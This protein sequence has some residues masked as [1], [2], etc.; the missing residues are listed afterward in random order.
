MYHFLL[1]VLHKT[2]LRA[3]SRCGFGLGIWLLL[4]HN[5]N[6]LVFFDKLFAMVIAPIELILLLEHSRVYK[7]HFGFSSNATSAKQPTSPILFPNKFSSKSELLFSLSASH[8]GNTC[9]SV[10]L[11]HSRWIYGDLRFFAML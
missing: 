5:L 11:Q 10:M 6:S 4:R 7:L 2:L 8:N 1:D 3:A 9:S